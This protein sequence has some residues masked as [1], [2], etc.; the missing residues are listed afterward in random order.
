MPLWLT[1]AGAR[2][3][4]EALALDSNLAVAGWE[5]L[6]DLSHLKDREGLRRLLADAY[7]DGRQKTLANWEAQL[8]AFFR[9]IQIGD[10]VALPLK[11]RS[12]V[13]FGQVTGP[14]QFRP[15]L[16]KDARHTRPVEW[17]QEI[18]RSGLDQD[19]LYSLGAFLTVCRIQRNQAEE[20]VR[21]LLAGQAAPE[22]SGDDAKEFEPPPDLEQFARDQ[23]RSFLSQKFVGH[24]LASLVGA[25]L[26]ADGY[27]V[28][29]SPAGPDGGVDLIAGNGPMGFDP[30][31]LVVQVKSGDSPVDVKVLREVQ[32]VMKNFGA[33]HGLIVSWSGFKASVPKEAARLYFEIRL[34]DADD[35][36][37][38]IEG[39][40]D[41]LPEALQAELPLKRVWMLVQAES[42][43]E[44]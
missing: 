39:V 3:E 22:T 24:N 4:R 28:Q 17:L 18:P 11:A 36:I 41:R 8:W 32:G 27:Q 29:E 6:P 7:P 1:R 23:I 42:L 20:R 26:V 10:L 38:R 33:G 37:Q 35:L 16:P 14:Y 25:V 34:W 21:A 9:K 15:D 31:R 44:A 5:N 19:L 30:P 43:N 40:Y 13:A 2:G 12:V